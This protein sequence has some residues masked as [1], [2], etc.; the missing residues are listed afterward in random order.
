[1]TQQAV[2][3]SE[4][5]CRFPLSLLPWV[6][7]G[8]PDY[9]CTYIGLDWKRI[10]AKGLNTLQA[11]HTLVRS[12]HTYTPPTTEQVV[13]KLSSHIGVFF[14]SL[15]SCLCD[16]LHKLLTTKNEINLAV[17]ETQKDCSLM[18]VAHGRL[19][20][21]TSSFTQYTWYLFHFLF[22]DLA[23]FF[24]SYSPTPATRCLSKSQVYTLN[25]RSMT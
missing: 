21:P 23:H 16:Q 15:F 22:H 2:L 14:L 25:I 5:M 7:H 4:Y 8:K 19:A 3:L 17:W 13:T 12:K 20:L 18:L 10:Q 9:T 6:S 11:G 24:P 1:M